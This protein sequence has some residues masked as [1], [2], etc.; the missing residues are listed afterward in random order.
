M[1]LPHPR[2]GERHLASGWLRM[3]RFHSF[4]TIFDPQK[5]ARGPPLEAQRR[6]WPRQGP[7]IS[8]MCVQCCVQL[9]YVAYNLSTPACTPARLPAWPHDKTQLDNAQFDHFLHGL[10]G[11][12][13]IAPNYQ[14]HCA[15]L[16]DLT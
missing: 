15:G 6:L 3:V 7:W 14:P 9:I 2:M 1:A 5:G 13:H 8:W 12:S 10:L 16:V 11:Q 4:W